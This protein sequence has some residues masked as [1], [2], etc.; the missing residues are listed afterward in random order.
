MRGASAPTV[1]LTSTLDAC[2]YGERIA[3]SPALGFLPKDELSGES[4]ARLVAARDGGNP[5][6]GGV[7]GE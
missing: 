5:M 7:A 1:V 4:L 3:L 6:T 2:D